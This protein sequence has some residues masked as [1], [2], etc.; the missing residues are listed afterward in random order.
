[1]QFNDL[2]KK[3]LLHHVLDK[4]LRLYIMEFL[5]SF[6]L[7]RYKRVSAK[8][9]SHLDSIRNHHVPS[10]VHIRIIENRTLTTRTVM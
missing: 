3:C 2:I 7:Q 8:I 6:K 4:I 5:K 9:M 10:I 1:M